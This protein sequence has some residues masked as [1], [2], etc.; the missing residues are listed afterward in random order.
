MI[1]ES[2]ASNIDM[3]SLTARLADAE[4]PGYYPSFT[5]EEAVFLG[6]FEEDAISEESALE[7]S[8]FNPD[9]VA[10]VEGEMTR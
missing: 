5:E 4:I 2:S 9:F 10:E 3:D 7:G 8:Y 1:I 6:R